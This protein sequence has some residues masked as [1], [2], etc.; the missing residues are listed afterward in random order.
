MLLSSDLNK[1]NIKKRLIFN[2]LFVMAY[3]QFI[4]GWEDKLR[5]FYADTI[6]FEA[7]HAQWKFSNKK[8]EKEFNEKVLKGYAQTKG[9]SIMGLSICYS[10]LRLHMIDDEDFETLKL[11]FQKRNVFIH[12]FPLMHQNVS[13]EDKVLFAKFLQIRSKASKRW[14]LE[15]EIPTD[16]AE[17]NVQYFD[18]NGNFTPP[19]EACDIADLYFKAMTEIALQ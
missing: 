16:T 1:E 3:E 7:E 12:E 19:E 10:L 9:K 15:V 14:I 13:E 11:V 2:S 6:E 18:E 4:C 5:A 8:D 17:N